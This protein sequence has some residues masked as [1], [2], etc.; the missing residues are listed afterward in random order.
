MV[1]ATRALPS[2]PA[3][4]AFRLLTGCGLLSAQGHAYEPYTEATFSLPDLS[5][6]R[7]LLKI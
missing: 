1:A 3:L 2:I 5:Y 4:A 6:E 7:I